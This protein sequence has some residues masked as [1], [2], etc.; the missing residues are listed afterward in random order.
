METAEKDVTD[1]ENDSGHATDTDNESEHNDVDKVTENSTEDEAYT[2][3]LGKYFANF[4]ENIKTN[5]IMVLGTRFVNLNQYHGNNQI[6]QKCFLQFGR[7]LA[8]L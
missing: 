8:S 7:I 1:I 2:K 3:D 6:N 5:V 4:L